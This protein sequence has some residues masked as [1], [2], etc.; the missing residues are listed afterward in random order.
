MF[1]HSIEV[2]QPQNKHTIVHRTLFTN[3]AH[4]SEFLVIPPNTLSEVASIANGKQPK[5]KQ[6]LIALMQL[7]FI[8]MMHGDEQPRHQT[9]NIGREN[10]TIVCLYDLQ[11]FH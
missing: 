2:L 10:C 8:I 7:P 3:R 1:H 6:H 9:V 5:G 11:I 4:F